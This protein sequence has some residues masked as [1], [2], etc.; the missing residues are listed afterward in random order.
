MHVAEFFLSYKRNTEAEKAGHAA[1]PCVTLRSE[2][3]ANPESNEN[4]DRQCTNLL[5]QGEQADTTSL[6][7]S[8]A[9]EV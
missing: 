2:E 4:G 1:V 3:T 7:D 9:N 8:T 5:R 6:R